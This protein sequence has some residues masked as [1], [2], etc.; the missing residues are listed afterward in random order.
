MPTLHTIVWNSV[1]ALLIAL[2]L[3]PILRDIFRVYQIVDK[4][5]LRKIHEYP[6]PRLGGIA[7]AAAFLTGVLSVHVEGLPALILPGAAVIFATGIFDDFFDMPARYKLVGQIIAG[8]VAY[9]AGLRVPGP[10]A[11][12]FPV[13]V[14]WLVLA[15]NAFNLVDGLDGLCAGLGCTAACSLF[16][17]GWMQDNG[18]LASATLV[19]AGALL[20]FLYHNFSRA[21]MFLGDS[22]ALLIGF[23][24]GCCGLLWSARTGPQVSM[25]APLLVIWVPVTDLAVSIVRRSVAGRPIFSADRAHIHH[26]LLDRGLNAKRAVLILYGWGLSGGAFALLFGNPE[27]HTWQGPVLA[28]FLAITLV[29]IRQLRYSEFKWRHS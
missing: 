14:F 6:I 15:S 8:C 3:T 1:G 12:S 27:L 16:V 26:R 29:G 28:V 21:T 4:P 2:V 13:T 23:L 25:L 9:W 19:L 5:G 10:A 24:L 20:G 17:M 11:I 7:I 22:G 18:A